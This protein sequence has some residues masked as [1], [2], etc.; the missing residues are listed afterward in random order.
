MTAMFN[1]CFSI[2]YMEGAFL[3]SVQF[4]SPIPDAVLSNLAFAW[5]QMVL[6]EKVGICQNLPRDELKK[7]VLP[8][9]VDLCL[10]LELIDHLL[11]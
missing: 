5:Q 1:L 6:S 7:R 4:S 3:K 2:S 11:A 8:S 9:G 10:Q